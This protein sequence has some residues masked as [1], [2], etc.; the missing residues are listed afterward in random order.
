META[1]NINRSDLKDGFFKRGRG[2]L[3][4]PEEIEKITGRLFVIGRKRGHLA[5]ELGYAPTTFS[6]ILRGTY[7]TPEEKIK[8]I[9]ESLGLE[10]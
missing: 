7:P 8:E 1:K 4:T 5:K 2:R 10:A 6:N 3:L 9:K